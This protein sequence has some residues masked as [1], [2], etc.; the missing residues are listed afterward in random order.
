MDEIHIIYRNDFGIAFY[1]K[2]KEEKIQ[3]IFR[4]TGFYLSLKELRVFL[5]YALTTSQNSCCEHCNSTHEC[6]QLLL[7]TP[8]K[9]IDLAVNYEELNQ[10][11]DLL[12]NTIFNIDLYHYVNH[13]S[14][15]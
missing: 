14:S 4:D 15:N 1:W 12:G 8:S 5:N 11:G 10:I 9:K 6:R 7:K 2:G 3:L 13:I